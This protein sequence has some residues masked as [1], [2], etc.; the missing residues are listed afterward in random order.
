[1]ENKKE[2]SKIKCFHY[3]ELTHYAMKCI[4]KKAYKKALGGVVGESLASQSDWHFTLIACMLTSMMRS[5]WY[6]KSGAPF[7]MTNNK[8]FLSDL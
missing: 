5:M 6:L 3:H 7:N 1:M 8:E 4:H 2:L